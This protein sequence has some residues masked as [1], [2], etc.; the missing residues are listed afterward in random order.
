MR[1]FSLLLVVLMSCMVVAGELDKHELERLRQ[2]VQIDT[3]RTESFRDQDRNEF[4]ILKFNTSQYDM[5]TGPF[6]MR[7]TV[8][9]KAGD[10]K[11]Y[12]QLMRR[13]GDV[14]EFEY[15]GQDRWELHIPHGELSG[16]RIRA[17]VIE[18]GVMDGD[19]FII[20]ASENKN[21]G[22]AE[23]IVERCGNALEKGVIM[24]HS[25]VYRDDSLL[26][27]ET[28]TEKKVLTE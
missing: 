13:R 21:A 1:C 27:M 23:E 2:T 20:I 3:I 14:T 7:I 10:A 6:Y 11:P 26:D 22:D 19:E 24:M 12:V 9:I 5:D 28:E 25:Y 16:P 17:Y 18:Y 8:G 15:D 4:Q